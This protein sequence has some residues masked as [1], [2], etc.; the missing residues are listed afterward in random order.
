MNWGRP[1]PSITVIRDGRVSAA[2]WLL[3]HRDDV[4]N[5]PNPITWQMVARSAELTRDPAL[6]RLV[7]E[8]LRRYMSSGASD[9]F[10]QLF[11]LTY[12]GRARPMDILSALD[13]Y[14]EF[15]LFTLTCDPEL[16]ALKTITAQQNPDF[17]PTS[18]P[19]SP[20]CSTHQLMGLRFGEE[21][22]CLSA[23]SISVA[24]TALLNSIERQLFWDVRLVDVYIQRTLMLTEERGPFGAGAP[25]LQNVL[26]MRMPDGGWS[27]SQPF[28]PVRNGKWFGA[29]RDGFGIVEKRGQFHATA[30]VL[31]LLSLSDAEAGVEASD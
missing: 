20:A 13:D 3:Q 22:G 14:Q 27:S 11:G 31:L 21:F 12:D 1:W 28:F 6:T 24:K 5:D 7:D 25:A 29:T 8:Y 10:R 23:S 26:R 17:C 18:Y 16:S 2:N 30:Q 19:L 15:F 9:P 4:L